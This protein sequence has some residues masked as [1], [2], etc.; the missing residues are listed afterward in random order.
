MPSNAGLALLCIFLVV[1][2]RRIA[3]LLDDLVS[4]QR[5]GSKR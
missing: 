2:F 1:F 5:K 4:G 3:L